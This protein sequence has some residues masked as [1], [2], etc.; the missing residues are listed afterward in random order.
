MTD[1]LKLILDD[2]YTELLKR[3]FQVKKLVHVYAYAMRVRL[4]PLDYWV[5]IYC[6]DK[7]IITVSA[8][9]FRQPHKQIGVE[10]ANPDYL[11]QVVACIHQCTSWAGE[12]MPHR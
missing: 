9:D 1:V 3:N 7:I 6:Q 2:L 5:Y 4:T 11:E 12:Q 10:Y 8:I